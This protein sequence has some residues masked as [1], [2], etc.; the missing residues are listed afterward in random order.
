M[1]TFTGE[2]LNGKLQ[3]SCSASF[4]SFPGNNLPVNFR[5]ILGKT[6]K[7]FWELILKIRELTTLRKL[8]SVA[9]VFYELSENFHNSYFSERG[10]TLEFIPQE[11]FKNRSYSVEVSIEDVWF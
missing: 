7:R 2:F 11:Y 1:G 5:K 8:H 3:F 6:S 9:V 4:R 10:G